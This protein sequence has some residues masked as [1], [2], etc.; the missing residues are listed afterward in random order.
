MLIMILSIFLMLMSLCESFQW[1]VLYASKK[2]VYRALC[3]L[4]AVIRQYLIIALFI[5]AICIAIHLILQI[6]PPKC[7]R[8]I[9]HEK[10]RKYKCL[11]WIYLLL[12]TAVPVLFLP[13]PF[14]KNLYG[15]DATICWICNDKSAEGMLIKI[16]SWYIW[17]FV[18]IVFIIL[19]LLA[20]CIILYRRA[21]VKF[22][23]NV[24]SLLLIMSGL[25]CIAV[26]STIDFAFN[27][28]KSIF[29]GQL[30]SDLPISVLWLLS[31]VVLMGR[32]IYRIHLGKRRRNPFVHI[33]VNPNE[34]SS[35]VHRMRVP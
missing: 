8:V 2:D 31:S 5:H 17:I 19:S 3:I 33:Q 13:W 14:I 10:Q 28:G 24:C 16:A 7:L 15:V 30:L 34:K 29:L 21:A 27:H 35:L 23:T 4:T 11:M 1:L 26:S 32:I 20:T 12:D 6:C 25:V 9:H 18:F 22:N